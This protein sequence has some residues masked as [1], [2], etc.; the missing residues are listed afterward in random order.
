MIN[1]ILSKFAL[2]CG[3]VFKTPEMLFLGTKETIPEIDFNPRTI[4][5]TGSIFEGKDIKDVKSKDKESK[6]Y[7]EKRI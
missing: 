1:K 7:F 6:V 2:N 4:K 3:V 5:T